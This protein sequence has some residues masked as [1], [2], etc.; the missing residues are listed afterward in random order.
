[1]NFTKIVKQCRIDK[2]RHF[3][4]ADYDPAERYGLSTD[5]DDVKPVLAQSIERLEE[6]QKR[7]YADGRWA[8]LIVLQGIDAAGKDGVV[9]H[10]M[11]G[12]NPQGCKVHSFKAPSPEELAHD[13][14]WRAGNALPER[15]Q[16]GIFNRSHYEEVLVVR[17]HPQ[18]LAR[19]HLPPGETGKNLWRRRYKD[20]CAFEHHLVRNGTLVLKFHLRISKE[21]Q[22]KRFLARLDEPQKRWKFSMNDIAERGRWDDYMDAFGE[23]IRETSTDY[24][25]WYVIPADHKQVAWLLVSAAIIEALEGL[26]LEYPKITG[27]ALRELKRVEQ[28]LKAEK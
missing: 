6:L 3:K 27:K 25:P 17:V 26:K 20:I 15:G 18:M 1:M 22:R 8:V 24:A 14:L 19:Q 13:F 21:E 23:M 4:L 9:K 28:A 12:V 10:V 2:P 16:I 5:I 11:S 7:L